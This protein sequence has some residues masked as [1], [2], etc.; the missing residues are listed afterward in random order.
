MVDIIFR[1]KT[2]VLFLFGESRTYL[3]IFFYMF[4]I[5]LDFICRFEEFVQG[6]LLCKQDYKYLPYAFTSYYGMGRKI[7]FPRKTNKSDV[8]NT[9][10]SDIILFY[11]ISKWLYNMKRFIS[12]NGGRHWWKINIIYLPYCCTTSF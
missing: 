3:Y 2:R 5:Y 1:R 11:I 12:K 6:N 8:V 7:K 4:I 9:R 10:T